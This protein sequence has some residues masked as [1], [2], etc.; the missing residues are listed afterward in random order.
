[1]ESPP[2]AAA[3]GSEGARGRPLQPVEG[4]W[5]RCVRRRLATQLQ[6]T[7]RAEPQQVEV[8]VAELVAV[9][10][11]VLQKSSRG[12][13][14]RLMEALR[15]LAPFQHLLAGRPELLPYLDSL[16]YQYRSSQALVSD[17]DVLGAVGQ[18][19]PQD[20]P[21]LGGPL[22]AARPKDPAPLAKAL[23]CGP[24]PVF[25][26]LP[27]PFAPDCG[28]ED[29]SGLLHPAPITLQE[30]QRSAGAVGSVL[31]LEEAPH[32]S[33]LGLMA[34]SIATDVPT[35][36]LPCPALEEEPVV[37]AAQLPLEP[38]PAAPRA[39]REKVA[40]AAGEGPPMT[41]LQ[42]VEVFVRNR[43]ARQMRFLYLNVASSRHFRPYDLVVVPKRLA[44]P[45]HYV[46]SPFGVLHVHPEEGTEALALGAWHRQAMLWQ[47]LQHI[48]FFRL[49]LVRKAFLRWACHVK[50]LCR[51]KH[52]EMLGSELLHAVPHFGA[53]LLHISRLLQEMRTAHWLPQSAAKCWSFA[54][55]EWA[56]SQENSHAQDLLHRFLTLS[57]SILE[58]VRDDTYKM[59]DR[60]QEQV[61]GQ[62]LYVT[63][64]SLYNQ[65]MESERLQ[66]RLQDAESWL[67]KLGFLALLVNFFICQNLVSI[68]QEEL[69]TFVSRTMQADGTKRKA[70]IQVELVFDA[71][72][73]LAIFP[74][75]AELEAC[76]LGALD[77]VVE[78]VLL[79]TQSKSEAAGV[80]PEPEQSLP[81]PSRGPGSRGPSV[82][83]GPA[84]QEMSRAGQGLSE[85]LC[86]LP[87]GPSGE[88][89]QLVHRLNLKAMGGLEVV[90]HRLRGQYPLLS[91][92]QLEKD[93]QSD[94]IVQEARAKQQALLRTA[95]LES[96]HLCC[97]Y[98]W[99]SELYHFAHS[100]SADQLGD[101]KGWPYEEYV[102]RIVKLRTWMSRVKQVPQSVVTSNCLL[103]VDCSGIHRDILPLLAA[104][105]EDILS[106]L[107]QETTQRSELLIAEISEVLQLYLTISTDI[108]TIAKCSQK[109]EHYQGQMAELQK[110]VDYV[111]GLNEVIQ[112]C[113]RP[114]SSSEES[115]ENTL[116]DTWDAFVY[117]QREVSDF[118]VSRRLSII[119]ELSRSLHKAVRELQEILAVV[120]VGR[121]QDSSQNPRAME[122][123]L[124]KLLQHFQVMVVRIAELCRS[125]KI[126]TGESMDVSFVTGGQGAVEL[127]LCIW[128]LFRV[129]TEQITEW[130][131]LTFFKFNANLAVE[132]TDEWFGEIFHLE[133]SFPTGHP[134][135]Q[136]CLRA[137]RNFQKYLPLLQKLSSHFIKVG[138]WKEI[139]A[140]MDAKC[141][142]NMQFTL[143][144]L[145]AHPLLE[146][147]DSIL[148]IYTCEKCRYH[149]RDT[150]NRMQKFWSEKQ[151]RL[152]NFILNVPY[153]SQAERS[154]R[155][156]GS[157]QR[158][159][160]RE[161]IS[162]DSGTY[163][164][165]AIAL[166]TVRSGKLSQAEWDSWGPQCN[167]GKGRASFPESSAP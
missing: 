106:L 35:E 118:I 130:K 65:R 144:Q 140:V 92:E 138:C 76:L 133:G 44:A 29:T 40:P 105:T 38:C 16:R 143:G 112:Q 89:P 142:I 39:L 121:F 111:R 123:E 36:Y 84:V 108:F 154:R 24:E 148:R 134:I 120:T 2:S 158:P 55:L 149:S 33:C 126:L 62:K 88:D 146:H 17:L 79:V 155:L 119:A 26:G 96:N 98:A 32:A 23:P 153:Q 8:L 21:L 54:E 28:L 9:F 50:H 4:S 145:L 48:P 101:M 75:S 164:L 90:G 41:G 82:S 97:E 77:S 42:A 19:F 27:F 6:D 43:Q 3:K 103:F 67:Q 109:L 14:L 45:H 30:L 81:Q 22:Q 127:H 20:W 78:S 12:A 37:V 52:R 114:L 53:A 136:A 91:R 137:L 151:F 95:L 147:S 51:L 152:V 104:I 73:K 60:L 125:Q 128:R 167:E 124:H 102:N 113:F 85:P 63:K 117:Q 11:E 135:L 131:C 69:T 25:A 161:Y 94:S 59:V 115:L 66:R 64:E 162:K 31:S 61:Q 99:L 15:L 166:Q 132:K 1:M 72:E 86:R 68:V 57:S 100:W 160:K 156:G 71:E 7:G 159:A 5:A 150:L 163:V 80:S 122:E 34:L 87:V 129:I 157:H 58:L 74:S 18:A 107:L 116:L 70:I 139:F 110:S 83:R 49:F 56:L 13:W 93:L 46:F 141:P 10:A 47:L 165:S